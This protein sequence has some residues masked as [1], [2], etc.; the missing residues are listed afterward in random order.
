MTCLIK[1]VMSITMDD[2]EDMKRAL[3]DPEPLID[4]AGVVVD[5]AEHREQ[6]GRKRRKEGH[7]PRGFKQEIELFFIML[8]KSPSGTL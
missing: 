8:E 4:H 6:P 1:V 3:G 7:K 2:W 5:D